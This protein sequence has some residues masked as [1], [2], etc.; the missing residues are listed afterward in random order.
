PGRPLHLRDAETARMNALFA[1]TFYWVALLNRKDSWHAALVAKSEG[2]QGV[3]LITTD[4]V[5]GE[6]LAFFSA[7]GP[8]ARQRVAQFVRALF[9]DPAI[10]VVP[11]SRGAFLA[12]LD[13]YEARLD[14]GYS[15]TDCVS[16]NLLRE[17]GLIEVLTNDAHF[18]QEGFIVLFESRP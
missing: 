8:R 12:A 6:V 1:D 4:E 13:L 5:L 2:I 9:D 11:S 18:R 10:E 15:L 16:M 7:A 3:P 14:K 17:R